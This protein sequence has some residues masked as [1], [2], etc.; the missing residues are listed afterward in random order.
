M[1][2]TSQI[3]SNNK[4]IFLSFGV[5]ITSLVI[6]ILF[7]ESILWTISG[8]SF[9]SHQVYL[10][11]SPDN[12]YEVSVSRRVNFPANS[13]LSPS[14]TVDISLK[15]A[16]HKYQINSVQFE[17]HEY[18]ELTKPEIIWTPTEVFIDEVDY[19]KDFSFGFRLPKE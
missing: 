13:F 6:F 9:F 4:R 7:I 2:E 16:A 1:L 3:P 8:G 18:S 17:I 14:I 15:D 11:K 10:L 5:V 12:H 19:H